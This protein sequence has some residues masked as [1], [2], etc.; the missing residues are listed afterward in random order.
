MEKPEKPKS[1][2]EQAAEDLFNYAIDREEI[3]WLMANL[4][5]VYVGCRLGERIPRGDQAKVGDWLDFPSCLATGTRLIGPQF[6][7]Q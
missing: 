1:N 4:A 5:D 7:T 6:L 3:K 2:M